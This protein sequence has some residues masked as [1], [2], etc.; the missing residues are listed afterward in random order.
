LQSR[1]WG[2]SKALSELAKHSSKIY[3]RWSSGAKEDGRLNPKHSPANKIF[4]FGC[5]QIIAIAN[6]A[7]YANLTPGKIVSK[8]AGKVDY[9]APELIFYGVLKAHHH[10]SIVN[11]R[12][13]QERIKSLKHYVPRA[14][15]RAPISFS[16]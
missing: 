11:R 1:E 13:L 8:L 9:I 3:Q 15:P 16:E 2:A 6:Q 10:H 12:N 14:P 4:E 5:R 7:D